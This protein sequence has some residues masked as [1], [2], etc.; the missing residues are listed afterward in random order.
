MI[1]ASGGDGEGEALREGF[2]A[3]ESEVLKAASE[4]LRAVNV[5]SPRTA[6]VLDLVKHTTLVVSL[7]SLAQLHHGLS[8]D[9]RVG[10]VGGLDGLAGVAQP[11]PAAIATAAS[12]PQSESAGLGQ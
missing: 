6:T 4:D 3:T 10:H 5:F 12:A 2:G 7:D 8:I 1:V 11:L 9:R